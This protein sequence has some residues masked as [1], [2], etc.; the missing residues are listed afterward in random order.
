M[1]RSIIQGGMGI[2]ISSPHLANTCSRAGVLGTVSCTGAER[3]LAHLLQK[4]DVGG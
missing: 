3:V 1:N 4:G 2:Y